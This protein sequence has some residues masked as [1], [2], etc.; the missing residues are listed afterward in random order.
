MNKIIEEIFKQM[1]EEYLKFLE[2]EEYYNKYENK[3]IGEIVSMLCSQ[4][5]NDAIT[6]TKKTLIKLFESEEFKKELF[7]EM[8]AQAEEEKRKNGKNPFDI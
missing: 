6:Y 2:S 3:N 7:Q 4:A 5:R 1:D 8:L